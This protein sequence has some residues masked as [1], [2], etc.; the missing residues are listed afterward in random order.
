MDID[1]RRPAASERNLKMCGPAAYPVCV[2]LN[3]DSFPTVILRDLYDGFFP[4]VR[5]DFQVTTAF[6]A[7]I[8]IKCQREI[9]ADGRC[10]T[11]GGRNYPAPGF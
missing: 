8:L 4:T 3:Y 7:V 5:N 2:I 10:G 9:R 1:N 11:A 6:K